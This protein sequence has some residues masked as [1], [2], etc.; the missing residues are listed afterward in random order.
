MSKKRLLIKLGSQCNWSCPH[1]HNQEVNYPYNE[2]LIDYIKANDYRRITFSGGEPLLYWNTIVKI[3]KALGKGY[4][5]RVV[6]NGSL[7]DRAK[8]A[9]MSKYE[10]QTILSF[11]GSDGNRSNDPPPN[12]LMFSYL[13]DTSFSVCVYKKNM[14]LTKIQQELLDICKQYKIRT[15][16]SLQPEFVH[17][18]E[19]VD[20]ETDLETAKEYCRQLAKILEPENFPESQKMSAAAKKFYSRKEKLSR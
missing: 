6:T 20:D 8:I 10:F 11:D 17:Q 12:Y 9:F 3:C 15:K 5:Y 14:N 4:Q 13:P 2:K 16:F 18:T 19:V 1:C 7:L